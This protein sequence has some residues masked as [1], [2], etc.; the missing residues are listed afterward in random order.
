MN[1]TK[2]GKMVNCFLKALKVEIIDLIR[3]SRHFASWSFSF[4][5]NLF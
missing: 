3:D 5:G 2:N 1:R 4:S